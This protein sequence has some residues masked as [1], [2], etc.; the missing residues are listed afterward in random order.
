MNLEEADS[1][2]EQIAKYI[3]E[4]IISGELVEGDVFKSC[5][6]QKNW[7]SVAVLS[8]KHCYYWNVPI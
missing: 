8:V 6:L 4:Q 5:A 7:M 1:L 2:S 3:S